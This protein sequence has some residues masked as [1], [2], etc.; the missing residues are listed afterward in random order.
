MPKQG[1]R[2]NGVKGLRG[3]AQTTESGA[4]EQLGR[5]KNEGGARAAWR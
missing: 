5:F 1:K 4:D 3:T 2:G